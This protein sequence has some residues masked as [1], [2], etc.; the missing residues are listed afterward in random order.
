VGLQ[1]F[2]DHVWLDIRVRVPNASLEVC[3]EVCKQVS[4]AGRPGVTLAGV[5]DNLTAHYTAAE[6][7]L[8]P[9]LGGSGF[10]TKLIEAMS[11]GCPTVSTPAGA[12]GAE[13]AAGRAIFIAADPA[14]F[15]SAVVELLTDKNLWAEAARASHH[16]VNEHL[17][18]DRVYGRV[19]DLIR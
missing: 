18:P 13:D 14:A 12:A 15:A 17:H 10:K 9:L 11:F 2:L 6:V 16:Y 19:F 5:V 8:V 4:I 3:G 7:C 1:W